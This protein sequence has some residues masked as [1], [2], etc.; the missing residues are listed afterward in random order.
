[1]RSTRMAAWAAVAVVPLA[2]QPARAAD[3]PLPVRIR[4]LE[5]SRQGPPGVPPGRGAA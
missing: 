2:S 4:V 3:A 1:M 5:G